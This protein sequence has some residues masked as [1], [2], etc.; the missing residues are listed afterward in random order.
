MGRM[1]RTNV[2]IDE[3]LVQKVMEIYGLRT[4]REAIDFALRY[5]SRT[6]ERKKKAL[7]AEGKGW[8][9]DLD[10]IRGSMPSAQ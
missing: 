6:E 9:G 1:V 5:A 7:A 4:K 2:V 10:E 8:P 3:P